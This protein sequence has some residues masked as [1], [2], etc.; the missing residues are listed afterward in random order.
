MRTVFIQIAAAVL[1][2][3]SLG[4]WLWNNK[5]STK[6]FDTESASRTINKS[7]QHDML[8]GTERAEL[9]LADGRKIPLENPDDQKTGVLKN[10]AFDLRKGVLA[11]HTESSSLQKNNAVQWHTLKVPRS[12]TFKLIL[13]DGTQVWVNAYSELRFPT[14]FT[15]NERS[16][17]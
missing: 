11:Y 7:E 14:E 12:G 5:H 15:G 3:L 1:V 17:K 2:F 13:P 4:L 8:P 10:M 9:V 6:S 16:N